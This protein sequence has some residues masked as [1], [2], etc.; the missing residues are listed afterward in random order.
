MA[1]VFFVLTL[2]G[3]LAT[4]AHMFYIVHLSTKPQDRVDE[5]TQ[6]VLNHSA[7]FIVLILVTFGCA[8]LTF[9]FA[10]ASDA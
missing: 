2:L 5:N 4:P 10:V 9:G 8:M 7:A 1:T 6:E 3:T